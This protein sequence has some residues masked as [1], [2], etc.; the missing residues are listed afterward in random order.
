MSKHVAAILS[1]LVRLATA[2][3]G[4]WR[5]ANRRLLIAQQLQQRH[6]IPT[7]HGPLAFLS[8]HPGA[9]QGPRDFHSGEPETLAWIDRFAP[10]AVLW[11][12]GANI[13]VYSL[14]AGKRGDIDVLAFEPS[15]ASYAALCGN[16]AANRL[17]RVRA[18]CLALD[19]TTGLGILNMSRSYPGSVYNAFEQEIDMSGAPLAIER[20]QSAVAVSADDLVD[21]FGAASPHHIKLDVDSTELAILRG[22]ERLLEG[23]ALQSVLVE[24]TATASAQNQAIAELLRGAGFRPEETGRG[25]GDVTINVIYRR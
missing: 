8:S 2:Y 19:E 21:R 22:A 18:Y 17:A 11:D 7:R 12:I 6:D 24:N 20:R 10:G 13:G 1:S 25:G 5:R 14:Y 9:L 16:I 23:S 3:G 4:P 15:P